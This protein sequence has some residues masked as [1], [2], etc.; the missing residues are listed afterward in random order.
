VIDALEHAGELIARE[1]ERRWKLDIIDPPR[2]SKDP[3]APASLAMINSIIGACGWGNKKQADVIAGRARNTS[4]KGNGSPQW[5]LMTYGDVARVACGL[6]PIWLPHYF[7][8]TTR[9]LAW[10]RY[11]RWSDA[12]PPNPAPADPRDRR[13]LIKLE[14]GQAPSIE[15][16]RGDLLIV[17][18][19]K[20][21]DGD[22]AVGVVGWSRDWLRFDGIAGNSGGVG[23]DGVEREGISRRYY[24]MTA[25]SGY[26]PM[27]LVR[28]AF[29][30]LCLE[31][32]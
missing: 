13:L 21:P 28:L 12:A 30:D 10:A 3:R 9:G 24:R 29:G 1:Y 20:D 25:T 31:R 23:P 6:D 8:S 7:A 4:Y 27:W 16:Q 19:G 18:D 11:R 17:G 5:C 26:R 22:H 15:P 14:H 2:G 32:A